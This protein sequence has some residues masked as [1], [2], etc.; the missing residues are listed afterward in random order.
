MSTEL[1]TIL[2]IVATLVTPLVGFALHRRFK[3][4]QDKRER[5]QGFVA[6]L[7]QSL[8]DIRTA[9]ERAYLYSTDVHRYRV[10][11]NEH[12]STEA[13]ALLSNKNKKQID[14]TTSALDKFLQSFSAMRVGLY[15]FFRKMP[16]P[17]GGGGPNEIVATQLVCMAQEEIPLTTTPVNFLRE[18]R[19]HVSQARCTHDQMQDLWK[20]AH[21]KLGASEFL[22]ARTKAL[23]ELQRLDSMLFKLQ[24]L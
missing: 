2:A 18:D 6:A 11:L 7:R 4:Q 20:K 17:V 8:P 19:G 5:I 10:V 21:E 16:N 12:S 1:L 23:E 13:L 22:S 14:T 9:I 15:E 24:K 3:L